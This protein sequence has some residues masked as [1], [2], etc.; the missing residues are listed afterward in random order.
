MMSRTSADER[1]AVLVHAAHRHDR[2]AGFSALSVDYGIMW[3]AARQAQNAADAAAL[4]GAISLAYGDPTDTDRA[5]SGRQCRRR[6]QSGLGRRR[7]TSIRRPTSL[8]GTCPPGIARRAGSCVRVNVYRN[9]ARGNPLPT[10][11]AQLV[12]VADQGVQATAT[13][14]VA[15]GN[16]AT[17]VRPWVI[18]TS[19]STRSTPTP[20][21]HVGRGRIEDKFERYDE[22]GP[23][24]GR[25][26]PAPSTATR[27]APGALGPQLH[28][29]RTTSACDAA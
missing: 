11:F 7:P 13:A 5:R 3:V 28:R 24:R 26:C 17:C 8:I 21:R 25:C 2:P 15:A 20:N 4:A 6:G 9:Q 19:G 10:F 23:N 27:R 16:S 1:G 14:Q 29:V 12:G 18:P 22:N